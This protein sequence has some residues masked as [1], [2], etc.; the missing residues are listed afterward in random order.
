MK[1]WLKQAVLLFG[2]C[3][4]ISQVFSQSTEYIQTLFSS[5]NN[6]I[7]LGPGF[8]QD[9]IIIAYPEEIHLFS[10]SKKKSKAS[11]KIPYLSSV[12]DV[13]LFDSV[14]QVIFINPNYET[15]YLMNFGGLPLWNIRVNFQ[16]ESIE[17]YLPPDYFISSSG[18]SPRNKSSLVQQKWVTLDSQNFWVNLSAITNYEDSLYKEFPKTA[19]TSWSTDEQ[20]RTALGFTDGNIIVLNPDYSILHKENKNKTAVSQI[21]TQ[22]DYLLYTGEGGILRIVN[23]STAE[24]QEIQ[25]GN[26]IIGKF[27]TLPNSH[28]VVYEN[29]KGQFVCYNYKTKT[30]IA[31]YFISTPA[32]TIHDYAAKDSGSIYLAEFIS[33]TEN[34]VVALDFYA[35]QRALK[36]GKEAAIVRAAAL[37]SEEALTDIEF[38][39]DA[40][41]VKTEILIN[42]SFDYQTE[43]YLK[44]VYTSSDKSIG[45]YANDQIAY[46]FQITTGYIIKTFRFPKEISEACIDPSGK[47]VAFLFDY[48][49]SAYQSMDKIVVYD[50]FQKRGQ[51]YEVSNLVGKNNWFAVNNLAFDNSGKLLC[52]NPVIVE[53]QI[54]NCLDFEHNQYTNSESLNP[55]KTI[56]KKEDFLSTPFAKVL[57][58]RSSEYSDFGIR[59]HTLS[60]ESFDGADF[61]VNLKN[62][63]IES[64]YKSTF[65]GQAIF[66]NGV[67]NP[68]W[69]KLGFTHGEYDFSYSIYPKIANDSLFYFEYK[70]KWYLVNAKTLEIE[71]TIKNTFASLIPNYSEKEVAFILSRIDKE[72]EDFLIYNVITKKA[73]ILKKE[74]I[75]KDISANTEYRIMGDY[76]PNYF[77]VGLFKNQ[78]IMYCDLNYFFIYDIINKKC[79]TELTY[80]GSLAKDLVYLPQQDIVYIACENGNIF[81]YNFATKT[82]TRFTTVAPEIIGLKSSDNKLYALSKGNNLSI[83]SLETAQRLANVFVFED[84]TR[85]STVAIV[86]PELFYY[87]DKEAIDA[88]HISTTGMNV[89]EMSQFDIVNNR[90]DKVLRALG[91]A[92]EATCK[93]YEDAWKKRLRKLNIDEK[94]ISNT[95]D[96]PTIQ[97]VNSSKFPTKTKQESF[98]FQAHV[99]AQQAGVTQLRVKINKVP[100][101]GKNGIELPDCKDSIVPITLELMQGMN[102]I[103]ISAVNAMGVESYSSTINIEYAPNKPRKP[104][105]YLVTLGVSHYADT[106]YNLKFAAKDA[107]DIQQYFTQNHPKYDSVFTV[108]FTDSMVTAAALPKIHAFF[109]QS[110]REDAV[111]LSFAGHGLLSDNYDYF[112]ASHDINFQKPEVKGIAYDQLE[113]TIEGIQA[114]QRLLLIDACHSGEVDKETLDTRP[115]S[116]NV[117][118]TLVGRG[119]NLVVKG[120]AKQEVSKLASELFA[121]M[122]NTTGATVISASGGLEF[123]MESADWNNG[124]FT[125][126]LLRGLQDNEADDNYDDKTLVSEMQ[127]YLEKEVFELSQGLQK[128]TSRIQNWQSDFP[129]K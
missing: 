23:I 72:K 114:L 52:F 4:A 21:E 42:Q 17:S 77:Y 124:L 13:V 107:R 25:T 120:N 76:F 95:F 112:L 22:G 86:T 119:S 97:L 126:C 105:L 79:I 33:A 103:S 38:I 9:E 102:E 62:L 8:T 14:K 18:F 104:N 47:K 45:L 24:K 66:D 113:N 26:A 128:P 46:I 69:E 16:K 65:C 84:N 64:Q 55:I 94:S 31:Q 92:S 67:D 35:L 30:T 110:Q 1:I 108:C 82:T 5:S 81:I 20:K 121:D 56:F 37:E 127:A 117:Q 106:Q 54:Y 6:I 51:Q 83:I 61:N 50:V 111:I 12:Y 43:T 70:E 118:A 91:F 40:D 63:K 44:P 98:T 80:T 122:R 74:D 100:V 7:Y 3:C 28:N 48:N 36:E 93:I 87:S 115:T 96:L 57:L 99:K 89:Y 59:G 129:I 53:E 19:I 125:Y 101:L 75:D 39:S 11:V 68:L 2:I 71:Y 29:E 109:K 58:N 49:N 73:T 10:L 85:Q 60:L 32:F 90:P 78:C 27:A 41:T 34:H 123:A 116:G 15:K 88:L